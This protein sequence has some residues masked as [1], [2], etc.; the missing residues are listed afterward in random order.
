MFL[1]SPFFC[2]V[3]F[4]SFFLSFFIG[5]GRKCVAVGNR[6]GSVRRIGWDGAFSRYVDDRLD[7]C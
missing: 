5:S 7:V 6:D 2:F 3:L 4:F 1:G